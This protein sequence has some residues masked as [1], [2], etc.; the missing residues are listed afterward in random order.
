MQ[1]ACNVLMQN[2]RHGVY[3]AARTYEELT[4][5]RNA[6]VI[7]LA[8]P[9]TG[10]AGPVPPRAP[11]PSTCK[12]HGMSTTTINTSSWPA[13]RGVT[14]VLPLVTAAWT[15]QSAV[16]TFRLAWNTGTVY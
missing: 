3:M 15:F 5:T 9:G 13:G 1:P 14:R 8:L 4:T 16:W 7:L 6:A 12:R 2:S 11:S 10:G